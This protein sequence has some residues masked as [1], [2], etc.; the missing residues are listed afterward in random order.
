MKLPVLTWELLTQNDV[1]F[2]LSVLLILWIEEMLA[3]RTN[4]QQICSLLG[5]ERDEAS[6]V[7]TVKTQL[8]IYNCPS[9]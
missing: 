5:M 2:F 3:T 6:I 1:I 7:V 8:C 9:Y 4:V